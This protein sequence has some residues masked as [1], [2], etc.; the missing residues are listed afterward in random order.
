MAS[1]QPVVPETE[2]SFE[3]AIER[4]EASVEEMEGDKL[5]LEQ[6]LTRYEEGTKLV[7]VCQ[8]KLETAERRI[9]IITRNASG[10]PQVKE[11]EPAAPAAAAEDAATPTPK[12]QVERAPSK[13]ANSIAEDVSLF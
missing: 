12:P 6:L 1:K 11:F 5:P 7:K 9:E 8:E 3:T 13:G 2:R 4:L 10:K